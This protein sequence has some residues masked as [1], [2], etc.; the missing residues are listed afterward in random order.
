MVYQQWE[1]LAPGSTEF[2]IT[3]WESA[4][5]SPR[6]YEIASGSVEVANS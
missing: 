1:W 2:G 6:S 3:D 5:A 4:T